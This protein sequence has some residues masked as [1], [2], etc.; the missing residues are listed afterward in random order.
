LWIG[1]AGSASFVLVVVFAVGLE[2]ELLDSFTGVNFAGVEI[3]LGVGD[4]LMDPIV[5]PQLELEKAF[6]R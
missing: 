5:L 1:L 3:A 4:D 2:D 6:F